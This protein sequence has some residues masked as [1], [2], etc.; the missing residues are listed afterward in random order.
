MKLFNWV[1]GGVELAAAMLCTA[2]EKVSANKVECVEQYHTAIL[3]IF[4]YRINTV[5]K[6]VD[7]ATVAHF[8]FA[9]SFFL[10]PPSEIFIRRLILFNEWKH[11]QIHLSQQLQIHCLQTKLIHLRQRKEE[12]KRL[13]SVPPNG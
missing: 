4:D 10:L 9:A 1:L 6:S 7:T 11:K 5:I 3:Q 13:A 12:T 2:R 8:P